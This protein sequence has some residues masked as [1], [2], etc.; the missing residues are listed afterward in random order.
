MPFK[1]VS[2]K[3]LLSFEERGILNASDRYHHLEPSSKAKYD[4][5]A[6]RFISFCKDHQISIEPSEI[7]L[8]HFISVIGR[9]VR[10][11]T[12]KT[13]LTGIVRHFKSAFP[14]VVSHRSSDN[15]RD[16]IVG[17]E[18]QLSVPTKQASAFTLLDLAIASNAANS[19]F[20]DLL[21]NTI[22]AVGFAGLHR[23][24]ELV[25]PD[26]ISLRNSRK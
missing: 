24:G 6:R 16:S 15:V 2:T 5:G 11:N 17:I 18:K 23:L 25:T 22:I 12:I 3:T 14:D 9:E 1:K 20:D 4:C 26:I 8:C 19:S 21:F 10:P 7:N 13:Y